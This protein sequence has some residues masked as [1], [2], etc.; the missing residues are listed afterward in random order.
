MEVFGLDSYDLCKRS[1]SGS[2]ENCHELSGSVKRVEFWLSEDLLRLVWPCSMVGLKADTVVLSYL[3]ECHNPAAWGRLKVKKGGGI[4][5][6]QF[7]NFDS[8]LSC[9]IP[10][11]RLP[12]TQSRLGTWRENNLCFDLESNP[13]FPICSLYSLVAFH[14]PGVTSYED[15]RSSCITQLSLFAQKCTS[16]EDQAV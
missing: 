6:F 14:I 3:T 15:G 4:F 11:K 12:D 2:C 7:M 8:R 5:N 13:I 16:L 9:L 1:L 10:R